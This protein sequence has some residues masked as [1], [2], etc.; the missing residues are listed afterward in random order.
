MVDYN[1]EMDHPLDHLTY[2]VT[3]Y[4]GYNNRCRWFVWHKKGLYTEN[5][6]ADLNSTTSTSIYTS[7][8]VKKR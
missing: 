2:H 8:A 1:H 7:Y 6:F 4:K 3:D 5:K